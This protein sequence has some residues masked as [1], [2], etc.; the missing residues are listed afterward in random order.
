MQPQTGHQR[1]QCPNSCFGC[2]WPPTQSLQSLNRHYQQCSYTLILR[3][4]TV[5]QLN[6][7]NN[8]QIVQKRTRLAY[9]QVEACC[10]RILRVASEDDRR[11]ARFVR[12]FDRSGL[13]Q[14]VHIDPGSPGPGGRPP[15]QRPPKDGPAERGPGPDDRAPVRGSLT[16]SQ[17]DAPRARPGE[18][19]M[20]HG[21]AAADRPPSAAASRALH[22]EGS[23]DMPATPTGDQET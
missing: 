10:D 5:E 4:F 21:G 16:R 7:L 23:P 18:Q 11:G 12:R 2:D 20:P 8:Y 9:E 17:L 6:R 3:L 14:S 22:V 15:P 19:R 1:Y 13:V